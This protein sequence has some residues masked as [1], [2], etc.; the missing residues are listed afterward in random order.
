[1]GD[2]LESMNVEELTEELTIQQVILGSLK[3]STFEGAEEERAQARQDIQT[4]KK[5][6]RAKRS[7]ESAGKQRRPPILILH[8]DQ[9]TDHRNRTFTPTRGPSRGSG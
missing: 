7:H 1:M 8:F 2:H 5:L 3:D 4:L 9:E 6:L